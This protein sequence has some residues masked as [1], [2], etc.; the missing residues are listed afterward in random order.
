MKT[1][2]KLTVVLASGLALMAC[3]NFGD[4][5][6]DPNNSTKLDTRY[7]LVRSE[8]GTSYAQYASLYNPWEQ[9]M[10]GYYS[11]NTNAQA[12]LLNQNYSSTKDYYDIFLYNLEHIIRLAKAGDAGAQALGDLKAQ[13]AIAETLRGFF[14]MHLT[15]AFG[16]LP[17][18]EA[19]QGKSHHFAPKYDT[20]EFIYTDL[21]KRL[22]EAYKLLN[23]STGHIEKQFDII[24]GGSLSKWKKLNASIRMMMAIKL[25]DVAP[26]VGKERFLRAYNDGGIVANADNMKR[27][28]LRED[29]N[30]NLMYKNYELDKRKNFAPSQIVI[31]HLLSLNDPRV[32]TIAALSAEGSDY[33]GF[34]FGVDRATAGSEANKKSLFHPNLYTQ[35]TPAELVTATHIL[36]IEAEAAL[37]GWITADYK[38]LYKEAITLAWENHGIDA[39]FTLPEKLVK[40]QADKLKPMIDVSQY[41]AQPDVAMTGNQ[42]D[43]LKKIVLQRWLNNFNRDGIEGWSDWRRFQIPEDLRPGPGAA[44]DKM[45]QRRLYDVDDYGASLEQYNEA[46]KD[47]PNTEHTR[48]WWDVKDNN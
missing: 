15:D 45:P 29:E 47:Q 10:P 13:E 12:T 41:L 35:T 36:L 26:E 33:R 8:M 40:T 24:Y 37:R 32:A 9:V 17:Y 23:T 38:T 34:T 1:L 20:Q 2:K 43:D 18:S 44:L 14:F 6:V 48:V 28:F 11:E 4:I 3:D 22:S 30:Q 16:K 5:N 42:E 46:I 25:S 31:N 7:L 39:S 27:P 19:M 21:D